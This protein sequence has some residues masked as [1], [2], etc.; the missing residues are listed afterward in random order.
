VLSRILDTRG[1]GEDDSD[2]DAEEEEEEGGGKSEE[3]EESA[4]DDAESDDGGDDEEEDDVA[5][6]GS[7]GAKK[8]V[9]AL[10]VDEVP[11]DK[12]LRAAQAIGGIFGSM[13]STLS[14]TEPLGFLLSN[15]M[16]AQLGCMFLLMRT[17]KSID[18]NHGPT[19]LRIRVFYTL[20]MAFIQLSYLL[21]RHSVARLDDQTEVVLSNPLLDGLLNAT[22]AAAGSTAAEGDGDGDSDAAGGA[23]GLGGLAAM[24]GGGAG[25]GAGGAGAGGLADMVAG[26]TRKTSTAREYDLGLARKAAAG[27]F[28]N[29][30]MMYFF[31]FRRDWHRAVLFAPVGPLIQCITDQLFQIHLLGREAQGPLARPFKSAQQRLMENIGA[32]DEEDEGGPGGAS[33]GDGDVKGEGDAKGS[34]EVEVGDDDEDSPE[35]SVFASEVEDTTDDAVDDE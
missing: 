4:S 1:G 29:M 6:G 2:T 20:S 18:Y 3:E 21:I 31:H 27:Q 33:G 10:M 24:L 25:G 5:G 26:A 23:G 15:G 12:V 8:R 7:T 19:L 30:C 34:D 13:H 17:T 9:K 16:F 22:S 32:V 14:Q 28:P 11:L 35:V